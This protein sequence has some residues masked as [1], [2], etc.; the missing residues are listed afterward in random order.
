M[1]RELLLLL[2]PACE[3]DELVVVNAEVA[4]V[5]KVATTMGRNFIVER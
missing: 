1:F 3:R 2:F 4:D 5:T